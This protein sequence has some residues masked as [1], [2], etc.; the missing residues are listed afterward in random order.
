MF[1]SG[2]YSKPIPPDKTITFLIATFLIAGKDTLERSPNTWY[3]P[4][5]SDSLLNRFKK[6]ANFELWNP[7][8]N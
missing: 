4:S 1:E 3:S 2:S 8:S 6:Q 5:A 7:P